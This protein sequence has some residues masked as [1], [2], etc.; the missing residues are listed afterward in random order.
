MASA[1]SLGLKSYDSIFTTEDERQEQQGQQEK[2]VRIPLNEMHY[3]QDHPYKVLDNE[4]MMDTVESVKLHG[5]LVPGLVRPDPGGG[6]EI[7]S[8]H[9]RHRASELAGVPDMP[10]I[11]REMDDDTATIIMV[12]S[13]MQR[14]NQLPS[15][16]AKAY[17][18][19]LE[20]MK[21]QAGRPSK[22]SVQLGQ[23]SI[24]AY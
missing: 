5:V 15:E 20:A 13:N 6:Y 9:R 4:E 7:V 17:R 8:G 16:K 19:R 12:D 14:E 21:R 24:S 10:V 18:M 22:N 2:V 3:F 11:V 1:K 23:N